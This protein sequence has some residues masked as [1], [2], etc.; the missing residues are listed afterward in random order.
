[1]LAAAEIRGDHALG[2][3]AAGV[4][5]SGARNDAE[6]ARSAVGGGYHLYSAA[7][8]VRLSGG[9]SGRVFADG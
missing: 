5:E 4:S 6:R 8:G 7:D 1:M 9:D 3:R 2:A